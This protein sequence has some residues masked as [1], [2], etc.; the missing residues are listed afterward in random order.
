MKDDK[1]QAPD[2]EREAAKMR[3]RE[4]G[5]QV[6]KKNLL[7]FNASRDGRPAMTHGVHATIAG[8]EIPDVIPDGAKI[9]A[10]VEA[11]IQQMVTDLGF[12]TED[13]VPSQ[14]RALLAAQ[15]LC[16]KVLILCE[17]HI[18]TEGLL[19]KGKANPV[20]TIAATFINSMRLNS[21]KLGWNRVPRDVT[22]DL[23]T[24]LSRTYGESPERSAN[25]E[26]T[27]AGS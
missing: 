17:R 23:Q 18:D 26:A 19:N 1:E 5:R 9:S 24:Y 16:L 27:P 21:E 3:Q 2:A 22:P 12:S 7:R 6:G 20:A 25:A 8:G 13:E 10:T 15:R 11:I 14:K 4:G